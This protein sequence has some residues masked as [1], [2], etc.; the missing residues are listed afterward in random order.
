MGRFRR[1]WR[2][3]GVLG[4]A[5]GFLVTAFAG[6]AG[7]QTS[8]A[9]SWA[10]AW[11]IVD[12]GTAGAAAGNDYVWTVT[13]AQAG[14]ALKS[15]G[16]PTPYSVKGSAS[17]ASASLAA[18]GSGGYVATF[19]LTLSADSKTFKGTW[20]DTQGNAGTAVGTR[21]G[22][23][24]APPKKPSPAATQLPSLPMPEADAR[25]ARVQS[26][27]QVEKTGAAAVITV[28]RDG[29]KYSASKNSVLQDGDV[30]TTGDN[31]VL[32]LEFLIGGRVGVNRSS[33]VELV[34]ERSVSNAGQTGPRA[35]LTSGSAW[36]KPASQ[37]LK[38]PLEIQTNGGI[39]GI[40]G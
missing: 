22:P 32:A 26:I 5:V 6:G 7:A 25:T 40:R 15:T 31:T 33:S 36:V 14:R 12:H 2:W 37:T 24:P 1:E 13:L 35:K 9:P 20:T 27:E 18:A 11:S 19:T 8:A 30:A 29:K 38:Q 16:T 3:S 39:M 4:V 34:N 21:S 10:G 28:T 23:V 17:G